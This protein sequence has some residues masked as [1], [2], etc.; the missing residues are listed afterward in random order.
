MLNDSYWVSR[1]PW[2]LHDMIKRRWSFRFLDNPKWAVL[3]NA[4]ES[5]EKWQRLCQHWMLRTISRIF[6]LQ[7]Y[8]LN[9]RIV[10]W[11]LRKLQDN[12]GRSK[13][14]NLMDLMVMKVPI[15]SKNL[16]SEDVCLQ[17]RTTDDFHVG[18]HVCIQFGYFSNC[19]DV[20]SAGKC[21]IS[22][23]LLCLPVFTRPAQTTTCSST[24]SCSKARHERDVSV[25]SSKETRSEGQ[26]WWEVC[27]HVM[28]PK[29]KEPFAKLCPFWMAWFAFHMHSDYDFTDPYFRHVSL[30]DP[31]AFS[32]FHCFSKLPIRRILFYRIW[33]SQMPWSKTIEM[34]NVS[35]VDFWWYIWQ[36]MK[37]YD[38][39]WRFDI[40]RSIYK[41]MKHVTDG[42]ARPR[43]IRVA[44]AI[45][46][47]AALTAVVTPCATD[48]IGRRMVTVTTLSVAYGSPA[49]AIL[50]TTKET[51][52][53]PQVLAVM[54]LWSFKFYQKCKLLRILQ[55]SLNDIQKLDQISQT[56]FKFGVCKTR[57][58]SRHSKTDVA[59]SQ[60]RL[61][62][63]TYDSV[64][65]WG[66]YSDMADY[67]KKFSLQL[68]D[69]FESF[70]GALK[71]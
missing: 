37:V 69:G 65:S 49:K 15:G 36:F 17:G 8:W 56:A 7:F 21:S 24:S 68:R 67:Q 58:R 71:L 50:R 45:V 47:I 64:D 54:S 19:R 9:C 1:I 41:F 70:R 48:P 40:L 28:R 14:G 62:R 27:E 55:I 2:K 60:P 33:S 6:L 22:M 61:L 34:L 35:H 23:C 39:L 51:P 13:L 5:R 46:S 63:T 42:L 30:L 29:K 31:F 52:E 20:I 57:L 26:R 44:V 66:V 16:H 10:T 12:C 18:D 11:N 43:H 25:K 53:L 3:F 59:K 4:R 38:G 32:S